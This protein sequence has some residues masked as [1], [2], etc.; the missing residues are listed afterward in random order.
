MDRGEGAGDHFQPPRSSEAVAGGGTS[1]GIF[2][3]ARDRDAFGA[4]RGFVYQ[5]ELTIL[6]WLR[7]AE[8]EELE[9]ERGED[10][11]RVA[12]DLGAGPSVD[13]DRLMEQVKHREGPLTLRSGSIRSAL[14]NFFEHR[15]LNPDLSLRFRFTTNARPGREQ[16]TTIPGGLTG[17][18]AWQ[19]LHAGEI[20][21]DGAAAVVDP[22]RELLLRKKKPEGVNNVSWRAWQVFVGSASDD[23]ILGFVR[24]VEIA[25]G[26]ANPESLGPQIQQLLLEEGYVEGESAAKRLY[27]ILFV[28]VLKLLSE[29]G[30]KVLTRADLLAEVEGVGPGATDTQL[31]ANLHLFLSTI[32]DRLDAVEAD[33]TAV[34]TDVGEMREGMSA[35]TEELAAQR[36]PLGAHPGDSRTFQTT[37]N[38]FGYELNTAST[39]N[40]ARAL[41]GRTDEL[42]LGLEAIR[43]AAPDESRMVV[44]TGRGGVG[45]SRLLIELAE[46][47]AESGEATVLWVRDL[48][49]PGPESLNEL[50]A[51]PLAIFCDDAH[52]RPDLDRLLS[53]VSAREDKTVL[54]VGIRPHGQDALRSAAFR[55]GFGKERIVDIGELD[56][57]PTEELIPLVATELDAAD[58]HWAESIVK[59]ARGSTLVALVAAR[60]LR[61]RRLNPAIL[62]QDEEV[63]HVVFSNF[64]DEIYGQVSREIDPAQ[65]RRVLELFAAISP[66][67]LATDDEVQRI[68]QF[69]GIDPPDLIRTVGTLQE[70]GVLREH[71]TGIRVI[72]DVLSDH[73]LQRTLVAAG[74]PTHAEMQILERLG[75]GVLPDLLR[76][77]GDLDWQLN[78]DDEKQGVDVF[79]KLWSRFEDAFRMT[80]NYQRRS[81]LERLLPV[82]GFQ[83]ERVLTLCEWLAANPENPPEAPPQEAWKPSTVLERIPPVLAGVAQHEAYFKKALDL[84]WRLGRDD[85]RDLNP[86]PE[87]AIRTLE[88]VV[89]YAPWRYVWRQELAVDVLRRWTREV[90]WSRTV[91]SPLVVARA[92]LSTSMV[93]DRFDP[94]QRIITM[95]RHGVN[96]NVT[97]GAR[98]AVIDLL[99]ELALGSEARGRIWA[100]EVL[101]KALD[102]PDSQF[103]HVVTNEEEEL[104][105]FQY[106]AVFVAVERIARESADPIVRIKLRDGLRWAVRRTG[107]PWKRTRARALVRRLR[108]TDET[109]FARAWGRTFR[110]ALK[111]WKLTAKDGEELTDRVAARLAEDEGGAEAVL[112]RLVTEQERFAEA[113]VDPLPGFLL[114]RFAEK[115]ADLAVQ[116]ASSVVHSAPGSAESRFWP[117]LHLLLLPARRLQP[118][119][120]EDLLAAAVNSA[121]EGLRR[122]AA[123]SLR[124]ILPE[125]QWSEIEQEYVSALLRDAEASVRAEAVDALNALPSG[126]R[127][128]YLRHVQVGGS[129]DVADV[130]AANWAYRP[131]ADWPDVDSADIR[132]ILGM[133]VE[134]PDLGHRHGQIE[135]MLA[136]FARSEPLL[137]LDFVIARVRREAELWAIRTPDFRRSYDAVPYGGF[138]GIWAALQGSSEHPEIVRRLVTAISEE[139]RSAPEWI[140][141]ALKVARSVIRWD[142]E[143]ERT[144]HEWM[145][146]GRCDDIV[147]LKKWFAGQPPLFVIEH[148]TFVAKLFAWLDDQNCGGR[149]E[150]ESAFLRSVSGGIRM[151]SGRSPNDL[152]SQLRLG[153]RSAIQEM[154]L[155]SNGAAAR[156]FHTVESEAAQ[157]LVNEKERDERV[158]AFEAAFD[159]EDD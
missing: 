70:A 68:A 147:A 21:S 17:I 39:F 59:V 98:D 95:T 52:R 137:V 110:D 149:G 27:H 28:T 30:R 15:C 14:A 115:R 34:R 91:H 10:I 2:R 58:K 33:I 77:V 101:L 48:E 109:E 6:R 135:E 84:L 50:P 144:L 128:G 153:A 60:L 155:D 124:W 154:G 105:R 100:T 26:V 40:H 130:L 123:R 46:R 44:V 36:I 1:D 3:L 35:I 141:E 142:A 53:F 96:P 25:T 90:G 133:L 56:D 23:D 80:S 157:R 129:A 132:R 47:V 97:R 74:R 139:G 29:R 111:S 54:V 9:L 102:P 89:K 67:R 5:A 83:P 159:F 88:E 86:H 69:M 13:W 94:R 131:A 112:A 151:R 146:D 18:D 108:E 22:M 143:V 51:G 78:A 72:P 121:Q 55:S 24:Q 73:I 158:E 38:Y 41:R 42:N 93:E 81:Y 64:E 134:L 7:L 92:I 107:L 63:H 152:D 12:R 118:S 76:N 16:K 119:L 37:E 116:I 20:G 43:C 82:A 99:S 49:S 57:L 138:H 120:Y 127:G 66:V 79:S 32:A 140:D 117:W 145:A 114:A 148:Q 71:R 62:A 85:R 31:A 61:T 19:Q 122:A 106:E 126:A 45:K 11:D 4:I 87:H 103:G 104:F 8:Q 150:I 136:A 156:F 113:G 125:A 65:A 75:D